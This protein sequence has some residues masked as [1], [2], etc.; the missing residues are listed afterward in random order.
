MYISILVC[1]TILPLKIHF[2]LISRDHSK[3]KEKEVYSKPGQ[4]PGF[5]ADGVLIVETGRSGN[6]SP[7]IMDLGTPIFHVSPYL[8]CYSGGD[9]TFGAQSSRGELTVISGKNLW[10]STNL[11]V[12][13]NL[14]QEV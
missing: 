5:D 11:K 7:P 1:Y 3:A 4:R 6:W 13:V 2:F 12:L 14:T 9:S 8:P 10:H